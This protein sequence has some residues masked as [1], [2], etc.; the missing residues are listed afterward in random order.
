MGGLDGIISKI[1]KK[2]KN[3][4]AL[5]LRTATS[6]A[7]PFYASLPAA[8]KIE[9]DLPE[10]KPLTPVKATPEKKRK[11][12]GLSA[13]TSQTKKAKA[14]ATPQAT[15]AAAKSTPAASAKKSAKKEAVKEPVSVTP[16]PEKKKSTKAPA[17]AP[18]GKKSVKKT[19]TATTPK[20]A[21]KKGT[22]KAATKKK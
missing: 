12:T 3:V 22:K 1:P 18:V 20:T 13:E 2:W 6:V 19:A 5:Y 8:T 21:T 14:I 4:Q 16:A 9:I 11:R 15:K 17:T 10:A 7:L